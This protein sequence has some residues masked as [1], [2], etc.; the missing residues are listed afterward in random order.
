MGGDH[1]PSAIV[2]GALKA[3]RDFGL[4]IIL[5]GRKSDVGP[6]VAKLGTDGVRVEVED[7]PD[8]V[9]MHEPPAQ[10]VRRK[11]GASLVVCAELVKEG[12]AA[13]MFSAGNTGAGM[14]VSLFKWGRITGID[15][16]A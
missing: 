8:V 11:K 12:R 5:V 9:E 16:P 2:E 15:R 13:A 6:L 7:A 1:A 10:A 3:S 14:A 4:D